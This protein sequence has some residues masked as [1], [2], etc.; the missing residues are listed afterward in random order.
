M[1]EIT[2]SWSDYYSTPEWAEKRTER[3]KLDG[4]K[5]AR[6][7]FTRALEVHHINYERFGHEDVS[8]DL[9]TLCKKCH[10]EIERQKREQDQKTGRPSKLLPYGAYRFSV[11]SHTVTR[12]GAAFLCP[13]D[14]QV[15]E[16]SLEIPYLQNGEI[17][18]VFLTGK[19]PVHKRY[20]PR[21]REFTDCI[22]LTPEHGRATVNL[23]NAD[24]MTGI[25]KVGIWE[26]ADGNKTNIVRGYYA[27][28]NAPSPIMNDSAWYIELQKMIDE[29][30]D[31]P[32]L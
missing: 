32:F 27:P 18:K 10:G 17:K 28:S 9:I 22:G 2:K 23:E 31:I 14:T 19:L 24:G 29:M 13:P 26:D 7:G 8:R 21:I 16:Y 11:N 3:L 25:C 4:F 30:P 5:C 20:L 12:Q 1:G 15:M 6:C